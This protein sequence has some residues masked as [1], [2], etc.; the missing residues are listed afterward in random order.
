MMELQKLEEKEK[1]KINVPE[2]KIENK[3][4]I[5]RYFELLMSNSPHVN[6]SIVD[7]EGN[8]FSSRQINL[9]IG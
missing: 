5:G 6:F 1:K 3:E 8:I 9:E 2:L 4:M 7:K